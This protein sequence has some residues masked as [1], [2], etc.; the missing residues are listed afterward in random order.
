MSE[1]RDLLKSIPL[2]STMD[3]A[4][5]STLAGLLREQSFRTGQV[6]F[7]QGEPG[8][9]C[10]II[11]RGSVEITMAADDGEKIA[12][13]TLGPGALFGELSL[14][15]GG[16]RI[17]TIV[18][19]EPT[20]TLA[21]E[22]EQLNRLLLQQPQMAFDL[23]QSLVQRLRTN[24]ELLRGRVSR[25]AN[26]VI[27]GKDTIG[28]RIADAV[29]RFGGSWTFIIC[30]LVVLLSWVA[31]NTYLLAHDAFD[32]FPFALLNVFLSMVAAFQAPIIMMSQGRQ[33]S[34]DRVRSELDYQ[35]NLKAEVEIAELLKKVQGIQETLDRNSKV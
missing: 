23:I 34:K 16:P 30:F 21:L 10:H 8:D 5:R 17:A 9:S 32:P 33:D 2:F 14:F 11:T 13:D 28:D 4:E 15:D 3:D 25:N 19:S 24:T 35:V 20:R 7:R 18:A 31:V 27:K 1:N 26:E 22:R 6:I 29:A 12:L